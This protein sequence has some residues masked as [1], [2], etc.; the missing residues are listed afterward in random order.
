MSMNTITLEVRVFETQHPCNVAGC[1]GMLI[2]DGHQRQTN[3]G[4]VTAPIFEYRHRCTADPGH[5]AFLPDKYPQYSYRP[6]ERISTD[7]V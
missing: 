6:A 2:S 7:G 5:A 1:G 3:R 4:A